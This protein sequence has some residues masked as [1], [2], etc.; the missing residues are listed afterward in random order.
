MAE[1]NEYRFIID[2]FTPGTLPMAR[3]AEYLADLAELFSCKPQVHF[4]GLD[5]GSANLLQ[6][7]EKSAVTK[8]ERRLL[9]IE[10]RAAK[11]ALRKAFDDLNDK[12]YED[13]AVGQ[14]VRPI[15][16]VIKFPGR[17]RDLDKTAGP[18]TESTTLDGEVI[19]IGG[20]DETISVYLRDREKIHICTASR[21]QGRS[22]AKYLFE[23]KVRVSGTGTFV[24]NGFGE[25]ERR[26]FTLESF[27]PLQ[28][29]PLGAV[30][31]QLRAL[32]EPTR[33][34]TPLMDE[35]RHGD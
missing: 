17:E 19:Q 14:L 6:A 22:I 32:G 5:E 8:V 4:I 31:S 3:L 9:S 26:K 33:D 15:G 29:D 21:E 20:R 28:I 23:G 10:T 2:V 1:T 12:L 27:V 11:G 16:N 13:N 35:L 30:I 34:P 24:R 25:W 18:V 7:V